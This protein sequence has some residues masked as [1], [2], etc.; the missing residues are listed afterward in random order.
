MKDYLLSKD[1]RIPKNIMKTIFTSFLKLSSDLGFFHIMYKRIVKVKL[2]LLYENAFVPL[3]NAMRN[4]FN[5]LP[6]T[7]TM[8]FDKNY[9]TIL[10][11]TNYTLSLHALVLFFSPVSPNMFVYGNV[12]NT[13]N[14]KK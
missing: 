4:N 1:Y 12:Y 9:Q 11:D 3:H 13:S 14:T 2:Y 7:R 5:C 10:F 8:T 6:L